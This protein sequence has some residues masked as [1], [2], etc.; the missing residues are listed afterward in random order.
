MLVLII[1][2]SQQDITHEQGGCEVFSQLKQVFRNLNTD[3][4]QKMLILSLASLSW[5][6][7]KIQQF[8]NVVFTWPAEL[9]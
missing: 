8:L 2:I 5:S 4:V 1:S 7:R 3:H 9:R 6:P